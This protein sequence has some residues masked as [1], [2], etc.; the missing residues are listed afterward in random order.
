LVQKRDVGD[1]VK[2]K[3]LRRGKE[4]EAWITLGERGR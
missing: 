4:I 2:L 1:R 3:I